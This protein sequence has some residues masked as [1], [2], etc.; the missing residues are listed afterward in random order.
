[1]SKAVK[2]E[3]IKV[4]HVVP[5][6][7][8]VSDNVVAAEQGPITPQVIEPTPPVEEKVTGP[9]ADAAY[10]NNPPPQYPPAALRNGWQGTVQ[11][12]VLVR[13]DGS[14]A[15]INVEKSSGKKALDDAAL[16]AVKDW[17]VAPA[18]RGDTPI[19]GWVSF[20]IEFN[21]ESES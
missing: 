6:M 7:P 21:L 15:Q 1:R 10:L 18:K 8:V 13:P 19:E 12:R 14:P 3:K 17:R 9:S 20:P 16:A 4:P 11:L 2:T 5:T